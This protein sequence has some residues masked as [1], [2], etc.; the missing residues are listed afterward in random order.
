MYLPINQAPVPIKRW[1]GV[2]SAVKMGQSC[3]QGGPILLKPVQ[4]VLD[5][6]DC[7]NLNI[8]TPKI[9]MKSEI[10]YPVMIAIHGGYFSY[11][12]SEIYPPNYLLERDIVLVV[13]NYRLDALGNFL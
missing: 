1:R 2:R 7:L 6:E 12:G 10:R 9:P 13:P 4:T 5:V 3:L 11:F 8:F